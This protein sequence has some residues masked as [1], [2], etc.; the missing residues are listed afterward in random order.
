MLLE[1]MYDNDSSDSS[2]SSSSS[3]AAVTS[4]LSAKPKPFSQGQLNDLVRDLGL[5]KKSFEI[6]ASRLGEHDILDLGTKITFC[7]DRDDLLIG[8][9][10]WK[11]TLFIAT[12]S[13]ASF[14][15]WIFQSTTQ[16]NG[17]CLQTAPNGV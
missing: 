3:M 11:V 1:T 2:I 14:Q 6:L 8:F 12:T 17:D 13:T 10:L 15:K 9:S 4:S 5:S 16:M 7:S